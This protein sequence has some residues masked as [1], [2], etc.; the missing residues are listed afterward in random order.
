M[1]EKYYYRCMVELGT[2]DGEDSCYAPGPFF[3]YDIK[4]VFEDIFIH[5]FKLHYK[6]MRKEVVG[7]NTELQDSIIKHRLYKINWTNI[8]SYIVIY[9]S[10]GHV[11]GGHYV[12]DARLYELHPKWNGDKFIYLVY[13]EYDKTNGNNIYIEYDN[14]DFII[15]D[16]F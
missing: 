4:E 16:D 14:L 11:E 2:D 7:N 3:G 13:K 5:S 15:N 8:V 10:K 6:L 12:V 1:E 9:K